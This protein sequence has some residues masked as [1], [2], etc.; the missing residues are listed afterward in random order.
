MWKKSLG[1]GLTAVLAIGTA[2][3][4]NSSNNGGASSSAPASSASSSSPAASSAAPSKAASGDKAVI[5]YWTDDRHDQEYIKSL[6]E[7][8]N[9]ENSD[10]IEVELTVLSENYNQS[11]DIAF[12]SN[13]APDVLRLK[14]ANT[15]TFVKKR[16][17]GADR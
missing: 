3:C 11:V 7:K 4:G 17:F 8:F 12:S 13:K 10:N 6:I 5:T 15:E 2:A 14:S 1:L 16:L 9:A